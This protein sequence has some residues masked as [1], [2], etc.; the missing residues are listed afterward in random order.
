MCHLNNSFW[1]SKQHVQKAPSQR[2]ACSTLLSWHTGFGLYSVMRWLCTYL[3]RYSH[4]GSSS[5]SGC[6]V[7]SRQRQGR[8]F[9]PQR[10]VWWDQLTFVGNCSDC[11]ADRE[12]QDP[13]KG[14]H[15]AAGGRC[16]RKSTAAGVGRWGQWLTRTISLHFH[17]FYKIK[18]LC[19][20]LMCY[21][22]IKGLRTYVSNINRYVTSWVLKHIC[23]V[24]FIIVNE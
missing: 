9:L 21:L 10:A 7:P 6:R 23:M 1:E 17:F 11:K 12:E 18:V 24:I 19:E 4:S 3:L 8:L 15:P 14:E 20:L 2:W 13:Q 22:A 5:C 16:V